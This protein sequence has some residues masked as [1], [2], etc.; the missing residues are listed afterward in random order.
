M[1]AWRGSRKAVVETET[2]YYSFP[3]FRHTT[4]NLLIQLDG[5]E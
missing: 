1:M 2:V 4:V 5:L 3:T